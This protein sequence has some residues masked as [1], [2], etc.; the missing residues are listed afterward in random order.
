MNVYEI[1]HEGRTKPGFV[2]ASSIYFA[3]EC[4]PAYHDEV[5]GDEYEVVGVKYI[6]PVT[7][8]D[9]DCIKP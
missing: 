6:G 2:V 5:T 9:T 7:A 1:W 3:A 8:I 4:A